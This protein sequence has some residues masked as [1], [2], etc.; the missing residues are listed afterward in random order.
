ML[1]YIAADVTKTNRSVKFSSHVDG[2]IA[3]KIQQGLFECTIIEDRKIYIV[4]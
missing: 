1:A 3:H 2:D 4:V